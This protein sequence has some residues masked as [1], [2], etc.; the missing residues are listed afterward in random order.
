M[1]TYHFKCSVCN[2]S[3]SARNY[4]YKEYLKKYLCTNTKE[5][6][7]RYA[8]Y[9]CRKKMGEK[10]VRKDKP[11][12]IYTNKEYINLKQGIIEEVK[13]LVS[14]GVNNEFARKNFLENVKKRLE[15]KDIK[16]YSFIVEKNELRG[17]YIKV[18]LVGKIKMPINL[19]ELYE[20]INRANDTV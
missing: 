14:R 9:E 16:E 10:R 5:L 3:I 20:E 1:G 7:E 2:K 6:S 11:H 4:Y 8:C 13:I 17:L 15:K 12:Y 19:K 18:P